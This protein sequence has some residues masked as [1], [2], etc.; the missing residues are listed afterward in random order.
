MTLET[1][2]EEREEGVK[3]R[4]VTAHLVGKEMFRKVLHKQ[5]LSSD[6][7]AVKGTCPLPISPLEGHRLGISR[8]GCS[9]ASSPIA[10]SEGKVCPAG[11]SPLVFTAW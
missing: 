2:K 11:R 10:L 4:A 6:P 8:T 7:L 3:G 5:L 1:D 9:G